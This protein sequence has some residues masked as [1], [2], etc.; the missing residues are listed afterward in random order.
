MRRLIS[1]WLVLVAFLGRELLAPQVQSEK[2]NTPIPPLREEWF[3]DPAV[4][5]EMKREF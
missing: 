1:L 2:P 5:R 4:G 3:T